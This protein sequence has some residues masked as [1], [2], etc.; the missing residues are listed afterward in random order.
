MIPFLNASILNVDSTSGSDL[1]KM[2]TSMN[3]SQFNSAVLGK[4]S[5]TG[6]RQIESWVDID[7]YT[8]KI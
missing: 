5:D 6:N 3:R 8:D 2:A 4:Q 1:R 7:M